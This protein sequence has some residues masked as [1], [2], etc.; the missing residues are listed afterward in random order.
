MAAVGAGLDRAARLGQRHGLPWPCKGGQAAPDRGARRRLVRCWGMRGGCR[1]TVSARCAGD[2]VHLPGATGSVACARRLALLTE[3]ACRG[4]HLVIKTCNWRLWRS[5]SRLR[6]AITGV[7]AQLD[8]CQPSHAPR[9]ERFARKGGATHAWLV[10]CGL[11]GGP[12]R[13]KMCLGGS[14]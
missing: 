14:P 8:R 13:Q 6:C 1:L 7:P 11:S 2:A 3:P 4:S 12:E 5:W 10:G 9:F